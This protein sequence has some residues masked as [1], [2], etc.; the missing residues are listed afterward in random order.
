MNKNQ[1]FKRLIEFVQSVTAELL[2]LLNININN[3]HKKNL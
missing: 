3:G 2:Q 1:G